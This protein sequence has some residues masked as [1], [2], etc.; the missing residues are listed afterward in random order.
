MKV[1]ETEKIRNLAIVGHGDVG[2]TS[3]LSTMLF[4]SGMVNRLG[5]VLDK[6]TVTDFDEEEKE[7]SISISA[8]LAFAEWKN[9]KINFIDTPGYAAFITEAKAALRVVDAALVVLSGVSG[10]EVQTEKVWQWA[11]EYELPRILS[12]NLMDRD[13]A[14][15]ERVLK[16]IHERLGREVVPMQLPIGAGSEFKGVVDLLTMKG[17]EFESDE[18]GKFKEI[19]LTGNIKDEAEAKRSEL[20]EMIAEM[21][22][23]LMEKYFDSGELSNEDISLGLKKGVMEKS[24]FPLFITSASKNIGTDMILNAIVDLLPSPADLGELKA[25]KVGSEEEVLVVPDSEAPF[26]ALVFKTL[27]DPYAGKISLFRVYSGKLSGDGSVYNS[28]S[29]KSERL[30]GVF[31]M[32][33]VEHIT[34]PELRAGDIGAAAKLKATDTNN[35]LCDEGNKVV[36]KGIE[37]PT[38]AISFALEP[39]SRGDEEKLGSTLA[40]VAEADPT[41]KVHRDPQTNELLISGSGQLHVEVIVSKLKRQYGLEVILHPPKVPYLETIKKPAEAHHRHKKQTGGKGQ[42]AEVYIKLEPLPRGE[43]FQ[44]S[45]DIF[46]GAIPAQYIPAVEKG[47]RETM[48]K[49]VLSGN[50]VIDFKVSLYDGSFHNVD[51]SEMAF[52]LAASKAFKKGVVEAQPVI[53]EPVMNVEILAPE[54]NMGDVMGD[55]NSRRGRVQGMDSEGSMQMIKA[56][57]PM[58]EVLSYASTLK[59]ITGGRG[60]Y[61][62]EFSHYDEVPHQIQEKI[63]SE[64]KAE[65]EEED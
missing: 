14:E 45:N 31:C 61:T 44:F 56:Q 18:S 48:A 52:K 2:K 42:F 63:V 29:D 58:A 21:D 55:L 6:N 64:Y 50:P 28:V 49:G 3:L 4:K 40:K 12:M 16:N 60:S 59:S 23:D 13:R 39:K 25:F 19:E 47:I 38:P 36:Y 62:M 35:T 37:F 57:V 33:G 9:C 17:Y 27:S 53:L 32:Q 41:I 26:S 43:E 1:Y 15:Y 34:V 10:V 65:E 22:D 7:R 46:G 51:S 54:E 8:A 11:N 30:G 20:I 5:K 24:I